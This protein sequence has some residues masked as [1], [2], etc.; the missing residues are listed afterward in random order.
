[1]LTRSMRAAAGRLAHVVLLAACLAIVPGHVA[2]DGND[3][4]NPDAAAR[5][6]LL[7]D[8]ETYADTVTAD[9]D[10]FWKA[11][12][13]AGGADYHSPQIQF[14]TDTVLTPCGLT[15]VPGVTA[16]GF[17]CPLDEHI[18][19]D[20]VDN[21]T[22]AQALGRGW[23]PTVIAHEWGHHIQHLL[24]LPIGMIN[25][26]QA[27]SIRLELQADC[28][29]GGWTQSADGRGL[30]EDDAVD[31]SIYVLAYLGSP[32]MQAAPMSQGHGTS[33]Q[34]VRAFLQG[35][36]HGVADCLTESFGRAPL[37]AAG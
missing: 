17:Y 19:V 22:V 26:P 14:Y 35:Y 27:V 3:D 18:Y 23:L 24:G 1:M 33:E 6:V 34:R 28:M 31:V 20:G 32:P 21:V 9:L 25:K 5:T 36:D 11:Q 8:L 10:T 15:L 37:R 13:G 29:A 16:P 2:A 4:T 7:A 12:L 30:I